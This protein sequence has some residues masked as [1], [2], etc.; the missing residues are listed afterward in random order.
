METCTLIVKSQGD[1]VARIEYEAPENLAE[2]L[3]VDGEQIIFAL[4]SKARKTNAMNAARAEATG[5]GGTGIRALM[6]ALKERPDVLERL[7]K[8][9]DADL[10]AGEGDQRFSDVDG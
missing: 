3:E 1:E 2:A 7:R 10:D 4:Y 5:T 8:E 6:A 9:L